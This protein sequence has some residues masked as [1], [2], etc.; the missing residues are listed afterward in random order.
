MPV[1][2][3]ERTDSMQ[4]NT[5]QS[6]SSLTQIPLGQLVDIRLRPGPASIKNEN[7]FL[8][9]YVYI[10]ISGRDIGSYVEETKKVA[11]E[12]VILPPGYSLTW[13]GQ[14]EYMQRVKERLKIVIPLTI[15]LIFIL[16]Y[17]N[18]KSVIES[19]IVMLSLPFS[20]VGSFLLLYWLGYN[21]SIAVW[22]GIIALAGVAAETGVVMIVYLDES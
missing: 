6:S 17:L 15:S 12:K 19:L 13:S 5:L 22:V 16:L 8:V 2:M 3:S 18:F 7:G 1:A 14:Y 21:L 20:L 10:D 9:A 11:H 4:N